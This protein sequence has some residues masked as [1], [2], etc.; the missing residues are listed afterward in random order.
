MSSKIIIEGKKDEISRKLK[1][2]YPYDGALITRVLNLDP[3][4]YKYIEYLAKR[5]D[6]IISELSSRGGLNV[7]QQNAIEDLF[8]VIIP[9]FHMNFERITPNDVW[10]AE[11]KYREGGEGLVPNIEGI[12]DHPKDINQYINPT[13][14]KYLMSIVDEKKS[15]KERQKELKSQAEKLYE[16]DDILVVRP[17]SHMAS[18]YYGANTKWCTT[19]KGS[20]SYFDKYVKQGNL[21]YFIN[22]KDGNKIALFRNEQARETS[23]YDQKDNEISVQS[24]RNEFPN[25]DELIDDLLGI[26]AFIKAVIDYSRGK[27][28]PRDLMNSDDSIYKVKEEKPTGQSK[29]IVSFNNEENFFKTFDLSQDDIWFLNAIENDYS[30]YE[31]M[32]SYT[33]EQ[34]FKDGYIVYHHLD[35]E[36]HKK[37]QE[38]AVLVYPESE[39]D[40]E[41]EDYRIQLS[42]ILLEL[43]PLEIERILDDY[44]SEKENEMYTT[45]KEQIQKEF[46]GELAKIGF[47]FYRRYDQIETTVAN[48]VYWIRYMAIEKTD[49]ISLFNQLV[50][51]KTSQ[52]GGWAENTYEFQDS[53]NFDDVSFNRWTSGQLDKILE[54]LEDD[55]PGKNKDFMDFYREITS[56]YKLKTWYELPKDRETSFKIVDFDRDNMR[57]NIDMTKR[58]KG[59][60][61]IGLDKDGFL[62]FLYQPELFDRFGDAE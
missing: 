57:M 20:R 43:F 51:K 28:T 54:K 5:L 50:S 16:D 23:V 18:C 47:E 11:T 35:D 4:G 53:D 45:A 15:E 56:K 41:S 29:I 55:K 32:D 25:Q 61:R 13:F 1:E 19:T 2:K 62:K 7:M 37:M 8:G 40:L 14:I 44:K 22:K 42:Q 36:N 46:R 21:Y 30:G 60:K 27:I 59:T 9:W 58:Y 12:A 39:F 10:E 3:T 38:I 17:K 26:K 48:L 33:I 49:M 31:F 52:I 34:E 6:Y 24:L